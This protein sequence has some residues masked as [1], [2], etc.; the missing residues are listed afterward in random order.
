LPND[1][2]PLTIDTI[3]HID[4]VQLFAES[5]DQ[6]TLKNSYVGNWTWFELAILQDEKAS[7]PRIKNG[8]ELVWKSH[9]NRFQTSNFG[10]VCMLR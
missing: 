7:A 4:S 10:W 2:Q 3:K 9:R 6:G 5:H 1:K 8:I